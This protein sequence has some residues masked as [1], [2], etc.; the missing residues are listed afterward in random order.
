MRVAAYQVPEYRLDV[1]AAL[2]K[3]TA[4]DSDVDLACYPEGFLQGYLTDSAAAEHAIDLSSDAF[5]LVL[6]RLEPVQPA[7]VFGLIERFGDRIYNT[8][9]LVR[10]GQLLD[11]YRKRHLLDG[12]SCFTP[13]EDTP[14][15]DLDGTLIGINI[16]YDL[17]FP[18][19]IAALSCHGATVVLCPCNNLM[20]RPTAAK[21]K[22]LHHPTRQQRAREGNVW[23]F[24]ADVTSPP[25][26]PRI[27]YGP[28]A[29][30]NPTGKVVAQVPLLTEGRIVVEV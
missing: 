23:L 26:A 12:E 11:T 4:T 16:C 1:E 30:I 25:N 6:S 24:T 3:L 17:Q 22:N 18:D 27:S 28:T 15:F 2:T 13:G 20:R 5:R 10:A 7:L 9:V 14:V 8:A 29:T 21:Y 19:G